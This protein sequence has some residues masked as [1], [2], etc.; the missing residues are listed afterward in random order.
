MITMNL[1]IGVQTIT[2]QNSPMKADRL[3]RRVK[4]RRQDSL[5]TV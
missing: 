3:E 5:T 1:T 4:P 2:G